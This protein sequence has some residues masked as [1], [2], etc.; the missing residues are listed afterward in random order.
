MFSKV[1]LKATAAAAGIATAGIV[2][3]APALAD[4]QAVA[5]GESAEVPGA[6]GA[7]AIDYTVGALQPS[8]NNEAGC[9]SPTSWQRV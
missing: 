2:V 8:G 7:G 3:A 1:A 9:G 5:F 4:P 6:A